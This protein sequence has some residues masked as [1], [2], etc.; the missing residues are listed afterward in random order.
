MKIL[1]HQTV[2][3][4]IPGFSWMVQ[5]Y[6]TQVAPRLLDS[7]ESLLQPNRSWIHDNI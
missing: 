7:L 6:S 4:A 3:G 1:I 2:T 5:L